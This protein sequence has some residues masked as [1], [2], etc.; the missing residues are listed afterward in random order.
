MLAV[1]PLRRARERT[2]CG[3]RQQ[4]MATTPPRRAAAM[5]RART[6]R[7]D[8]AGDTVIALVDTAGPGCDGG[9]F[10]VLARARARQGVRVRVTLRAGA[11]TRSSRTTLRGFATPRLS[12]RV[13]ATDPLQGTP[14][15]VCY[16]S[17]G[18][19][20]ATVTAALTRT[21]RAASGAS[22][23]R[24]ASAHARRGRVRDQPALG[25][26]LLAIAGLGLATSR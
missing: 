8:V 26:A 4:A 23:A 21:R 25:R 19:S 12:G 22:V 2:P 13:D 9:T 3:A 14:R 15:L 6:G 11:D 18:R 5:Q 10:V 1:T 16:S 20:S 24:A 7:F 17:L